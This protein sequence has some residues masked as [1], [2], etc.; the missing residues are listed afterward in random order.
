MFSGREYGEGVFDLSRTN[1]QSHTDS[2]EYRRESLR[3]THEINAIVTPRNI[4]RLLKRL[5]ENL[6]TTM[7][8]KK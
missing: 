6:P 2:K 5:M 1:E 8:I 4:T 7:E 3:N